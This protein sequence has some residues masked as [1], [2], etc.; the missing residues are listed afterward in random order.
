[1]ND[2][3]RTLCALLAVALLLLAGCGQSGGEVPR[4]SR[5]TQDAQEPVA[6]DTILWINGTHAVLTEL[7]GWDF[8]LFGG[9]EPGESSEKLMAELL[10]E[11]WGVTDRQSAIENMDWLLTEGHRT[12]YADLMAMLDEEGMTHSS[13]EEVAEVLG[14]I[15]EDENTG[16]FLARAYDGYRAK[17]PR[18]IDGW[19]LSRAMSLLGWYYIAGYYTEG[20]ALDKALEVGQAI[21]AEFSSWDELMD[22]YLL[23]YEYWSEEDSADRRAVYEDLKTRPGSPYA[24]DWNTPLER[25]WTPAESVPGASIPQDQAAVP[26]SEG[27]VYTK[28]FGGYTVPEGWEESSQYSAGGKYF[29]LPADQKDAEYPDNVSV[30]TGTNRYAA[31]E[32]EQFREAV[33]SQLM[34]QLQGVDAELLGDG[35]FTN[36]G[37][38][39]YVFTIQEP[40]VVTRQYYVVGDQKYCLIHLTNYTGGQ[41]ADDAA[42]LMAESF[43]WA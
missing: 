22:S 13:T 8:S 39:L 20:E 41:E 30:E 2:S 9:M 33:M 12:D 14:T 27:M 23:G 16:R 42:R 29:Y 36:A 7:N 26:S 35:T 10:E 38:V 6:E 21:Q 40:D 28:A 11:W 37:D 4:D 43:R 3:K 31:E 5:G 18:A 24:L 1:M 15:F 34:A 19:D 25:S 32:H 17:G